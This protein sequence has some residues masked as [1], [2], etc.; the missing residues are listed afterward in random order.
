MNLRETL[1]LALKVSRIR[2]WFY[3]TGPFTVGCI[4]GASRYVDLLNPWFFVYF[5]YFLFPANVLLYGVN[6]Y[7]DFDTDFLNPKKDEK[8][9]RVKIVEKKKL[10]FV[11]FVMIFCS[12]GLL[13]FMQSIFERAIF[14]VF[15]LLSYFYSAKPL[16]LKEKPFIDSASNVL[17]IIPGVFAYY[18]VSGRLPPTIIMVAGFLHTFAMHLFSAIPDIEF[19][20]ETGIN[21]TAVYFGRKLSLLICLIAWLG[22]AFIT[23]SIGGNSL[24]KYLPIIYPLLIVNIL[25]RDL[26]VESVYWYYPF[27]NVGFGALLFIIEAVR[28]PWG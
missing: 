9:Y 5:I 15:L 23:I 26:K 11:I 18:V 25:F 22:L 8:E 17:Y 12:I 2:F 21:T 28:T 20:K 3:L 24:F 19:D 13:I 4:Y 1:S 10:R 16:R 6:D 27:I 14:I 7:W